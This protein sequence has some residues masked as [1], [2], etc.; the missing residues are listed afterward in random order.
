M[1]SPKVIYTMEKASR[2]EEIEESQDIHEK[3][4]KKDKGQD[5]FPMDYYKNSLLPWHLFLRK[6]T[7]RLICTAILKNTSLLEN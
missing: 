7:T 5:G 1:E 2:E 6:Y 3:Y 4:N